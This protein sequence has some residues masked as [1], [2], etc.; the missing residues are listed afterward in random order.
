MVAVSK[1]RCGLNLKRKIMEYIKVLEG[2][3]EIAREAGQAILTVYNNPENIGVEHKADDSP[4]T[5]ADKAAN[6]VICKGLEELPLQFPILSEEN[7]G[8]P[9]EQRAQMDYFWMVDPLDG[10]KEFIKRNGEFTVNIALIHKNR[11]VMGIVYIPIQDKM[12]WGAEGEGAF[13][14]EGTQAVKALK[15]PT[16]STTAPNMKVVC[17]RS[18][19]NDATQLFVDKLE[20]PELVA[21]GSSLKFLL[22]AEKKAHFYPR[23]APTMEWD[24]AAAQAVLEAAGGTVLQ[25]GTNK[26]VVYNKENLLNPHFIAQGE[27]ID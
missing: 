2:V 18:H 20:S 6:A 17:S 26:P 16:C 5:L 13:M 25:F 23:L 10:T 4:I 19:L 7:A 22:I 9:Y 11:P 3:K 8:I 15:V 12:Y 24:T 1:K 21:V 27:V 14:Q